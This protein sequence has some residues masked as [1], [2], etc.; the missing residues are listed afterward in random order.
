M[1]G[2]RIRYKISWSHCEDSPGNSEYLLFASFV[3]RSPIPKTLTCCEAFGAI[4]KRMLRFDCAS[5]RK[6]QRA[7]NRDETA[8]DVDIA[9]NLTYWKWGLGKGSSASNMAIWG[10]HSLNW[11][12]D[13]KPRILMGL[14]TP[15]CDKW[16]VEHTKKASNL[17]HRFMWHVLS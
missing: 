2:S 13:S 6:T 11:G 4:Q 7:K 14:I 16:M 8:I 15:C 10:I 3:E 5:W 12:Y 9:G 17:P 1:I